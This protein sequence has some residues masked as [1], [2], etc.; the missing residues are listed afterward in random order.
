MTH[1]VVLVDLHVG[2]RR[3]LIFVVES[4]HVDNIL[5]VFAGLVQLALAD[6]VRRWERTLVVD[7]L[8]VVVSGEFDRLVWLNVVHVG[9]VRVFHVI[10]FDNWL[11]INVFQ[12]SL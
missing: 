9:D 11:V 3:L 1:H 8:V 10:F 12:R 6:H 5:E 2:V 7:V 4:V